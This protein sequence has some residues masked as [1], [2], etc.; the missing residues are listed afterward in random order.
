MS[1]LVSFIFRKF[2]ISTNEYIKHIQYAYHSIWNL[3]SR[4][5]QYKFFETA[6][7]NIEKLTISQNAWAKSKFWIKI[8]TRH[9]IPRRMIYYGDRFY[10][11]LSIFSIEIKIA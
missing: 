1:N 7:A 9:K 8:R 5:V 10:I 3:I 6:H 4:S 11:I 2:W